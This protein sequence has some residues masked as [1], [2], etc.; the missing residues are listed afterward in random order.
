MPFYFCKISILLSLSTNVKKSKEDFS[1]CG[2]KKKK[3]NAPFV[4]ILLIYEISTGTLYCQR[5]QETH[6]IFSVRM[7]K[8]YDLHFQ[9]TVLI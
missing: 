9:K 8:I 4:Y 2:K 6:A 5:A 7:K 1:S 3:G